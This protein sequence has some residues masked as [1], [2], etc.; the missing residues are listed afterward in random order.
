M[1]RNKNI[2]MHTVCGAPFL[3]HEGDANADMDKII[4]LND[5]AAWLW[6]TMGMGDFTP[7]MLAEKLVAEYDVTE[8]DARRD[9]SAFIS[10]LQAHGCL[11]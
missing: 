7:E 10:I 1:R 5:T 11:E 4:T 8:E 9:V 2:V 6:E 3:A